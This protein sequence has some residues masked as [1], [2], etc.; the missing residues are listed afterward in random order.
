MATTTPNY[1]WTVPTSTD[2][3]KDGATAIETLG[4]AIDASLVDLRGGTTGQVLKKASATQMDFEWGA[5]SSGLTLI[6]T[7]SFSAV[8][9]QSFNSVFSA[10]YENYLALITITSVSANNGMNMKMRT[11]GTDNSNTD[12]Y[13]GGFFNRSNSATVSGQNIGGATNFELG[14]AS[15]TFPSSRYKID[16]STPFLTQNTG[17]HI[18]SAGADGTSHYGRYVG[19]NFIQTTSFD[20]FSIIP[21]TGTITGKVSIYGYSF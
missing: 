17:V 18:S 13:G 19:A 8:S 5:A 20:G 4:D 3:V 7:T 14:G 11:S 21:T 1:G 16:F 9:S 6:S 2:L 15:S 10:T 12:Y